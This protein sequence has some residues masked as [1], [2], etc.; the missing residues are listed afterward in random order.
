M[1]DWSVLSEK[2]IET[3]EDYVGAGGGAG[4]RR[5]LDLEPAEVID[6]VRR[7]GVRGRGGAGFPTGTKWASVVEAGADSEVY[8]VCN[9]AEGEP[10]TFKDRPLLARNPY[11]VIEGCLIALHAVQAV[12]GFIAT[13]ARFTHEVE[14]LVEARDAMAETGW[15][16]AADIR[17]VPGPDE[18]LF[19]E[20]S[21][22]LEVVEHKLPMPRIL[23]PYMQGLFATMHT[24]N[25]TVV[26]NVE[27]LSHVAQILARGADAF[28]AVGTEESPG[29][30]V[31]TVVGDVDS[32]GVYELPLGTS[33]RTL[34]EDIAGA[35][36][37]QAI[38]SGTSNPVITPDVLDL[39]MDFDSF[40][41]AGTGLGSG[42]FI[43]Y[44]TSRDVVQVVAMLSR[45]LAVE[46][47]GQCLPCKLGNGEVY[48]RLERLVNGE[49]TRG[50]IEE[51]AKRCHTMTDGNR[52]FLPVGAAYTVGSTLDAFPEAFAA[53]IGSPS[54]PEVAVDVPKIV[55]LEHST[56]EVRF[57]PEYLRK[58]SNWSYEPEGVIATVP[59][60]TA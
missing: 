14:R 13:K 58:N 59:P 55:D 15:H 56:G 4:L 29:T 50:D 40:R 31:F 48:K 17:I 33:L 12:R 43:V 35:H 8:L 52:C 28:R 26:N 42:G 1:A 11:Q 2:P 41:E 10:G 20:E 18:Y 39:P 37:I 3:L 45:F 6:E 21:A 51:I 22:M 38:Y 7:S 30:M 47:C 32:P 54:P 16:R 25:P 53:R 24:P 27:T 49:G 19:G 36:D 57:D 23:P 60:R 5:A 34:V 46:S 9:G 44:D